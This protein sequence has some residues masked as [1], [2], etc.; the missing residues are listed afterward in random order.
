MKVINPDL[1][2]QKLE[3]YL[4]QAFVL[5]E[6]INTLIDSEWGKKGNDWVLAITQELSEFNDHIGW[7]WWKH[8]EPDYEQAFIELVD[9]LHFKLSWLLE[10]AGLA[11]C[12]SNFVTPIVNNLL[13]DMTSE[14][15]LLQV[16]QEVS[17]RLLT[18]RRAKI[19]ELGYM[20]RKLGKT[21]EEFFQMFIAKNTLNIFR[22]Q[23]GYKDGSY[24]KM[25]GDLEDN[26]V[27]TNIL[28]INPDLYT[29]TD[30]LLL[31]LKE[32]YSKIPV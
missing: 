6:T 11:A 5:Q 27:L 17:G 19:P 23:N 28:K 29:E 1:E 3:D 12:T 4:H 7:K 32:E 2:I 10:K 21:L 25:W 16:S 24:V 26:E 13:L 30:K 18:T 9:V 15:T 22:Q 20:V 14:R 8:Q 31:T